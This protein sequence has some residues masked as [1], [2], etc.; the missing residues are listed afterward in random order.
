MGQGIF[1]V[2]HFSYFTVYAR[3]SC[4]Q[5]ATRKSIVTF[6]RLALLVVVRA[7]H[8]SLL[9]RFSSV[10]FSSCLLL[11]SFHPWKSV[12]TA[13]CKKQKKRRL[14]DHVVH[15][16]GAFIVQDHYCWRGVG[17]SIPHARRLKVC[18]N[19]RSSCHHVINHQSFSEHL[20]IS[21]T[22]WM[23]HSSLTENENENKQGIYGAPVFH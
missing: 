5:L 17:V 14:L 12:S 6:E 1:V 23:S 9:I 20:H 2:G 3:N 16:T 19:V 4:G 7:W 15:C 13:S 11:L 10:Q 22:R 21:S 18:F 8:S